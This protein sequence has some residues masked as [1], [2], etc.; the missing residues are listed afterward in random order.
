MRSIIDC[1]IQKAEGVLG[2]QVPGGN[3]EIDF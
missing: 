2:G 3:A 1:E